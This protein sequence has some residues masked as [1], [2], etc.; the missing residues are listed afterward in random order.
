MI[1]T[2]YIHIV[3]DLRQKKKIE[4]MMGLFETSTIDNV[5]WDFKTDKPINSKLRKIDID[6]GK[7]KLRTKPIYNLY[8]E[9]A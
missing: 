5:D 6:C 8:H 2:E 7:V 4:K 1:D 9:N 3:S